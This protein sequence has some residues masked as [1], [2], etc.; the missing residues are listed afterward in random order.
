MKKWL[1][2][3]NKLH[4]L[5]EAVDYDIESYAGSL[6]GLLNRMPSEIDKLT[7]QSIVNGHNHF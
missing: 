2:E 1:S 4:K 6:R 7:G 3:L 5:T